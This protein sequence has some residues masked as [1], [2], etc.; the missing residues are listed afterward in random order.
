MA[1]QQERNKA[2]YEQNK[3]REKE[4]AR[5]Y[6]HENK[7]SDRP[8]EEKGV[9]RGIPQGEQA[10]KDETNAGSEGGAKPDTARKVRQ[11]S[12]VQRASEAKSQREL[13]PES[14]GETD[15]ST[16][17]QLRDNPRAVR[18]DVDSTGRGVRDLRSEGHRGEEA[19]QA[20]EVSVCGSQPSNGGNPGNPLP[21]VQLRNRSLSGQP[22]SALEGSGISE[23]LQLVIWCNLNDEQ[24]ALESGLR[25]H[26]ISVSSIY[27]SLSPEEVEARLYEWK[28]KKT[29]VLLGKPSMLESGT[30]LQQAH[31][32]IYVG[33][34]FK[35][36]D[37]IQSIHRLQRYGQ[38]YTVQIHCI[39]T[40]AED[41]VVNILTGKWR[42][43]DEMVAR[44][45]AIVQEYG[46]TN[47]ALVGEM[48][49]TLGVTRQE[50]RGEFYTAINNDCTIEAMA[51]A[52]NSVDEIISSIPFRQSF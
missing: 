7:D 34:D 42:Q 8:R 9:Q 49:R 26:G 22:R 5:L 25:G 3:E 24:R 11:R 15:A 41:S 6:Y 17:K 51:M 2:F 43:H 23:Q 20:T 21:S 38:T 50:Q 18:G 33:L 47:E 28:D 27:G 32:A 19:E 36:R 1:T 16:E 46:L 48:Q 29:Q 40:D 14:A 31:I 37:F 39:H 12:R 10:Q 13:E 35:F 30:N 44:M 45:R 4:R 52:D